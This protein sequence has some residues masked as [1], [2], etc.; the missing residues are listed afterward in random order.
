MNRTDDHYATKSSMSTPLI[1]RTP[2]IDWSGASRESDRGNWECWTLRKRN[3]DEPVA[4]LNEESAQKRPSGRGMK[5]NE[6]G[7]CSQCPSR[8]SHRDGTGA[9]YETRVHTGQ[10]ASKRDPGPSVATS[11]CS[12][13]RSR[14]PLPAYPGN[15]AASSHRDKDVLSHGK[16]SAN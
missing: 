5:Q 11:T 16:T 13:Q 15:P 9:V 12:E 2:K 4:E 7:F 1:L 8:E 14:R 3:N 10:E 6:I